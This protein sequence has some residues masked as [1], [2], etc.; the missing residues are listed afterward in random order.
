MTLRQRPK[1]RAEKELWPWWWK[2]CGELTELAASGAVVVVNE[3]ELNETAFS[4]LALKQVDRLIHPLAF[5][6][7][8]QVCEKLSGHGVSFCDEID[9]QLCIGGSFDLSEDPHVF[10][11]VTQLQNKLD[12]EAGKRQFLPFSFSD[13]DAAYPAI[14]EAGSWIQAHLQELKKNTGLWLRGC[15]DQLENAI[16]YISAALK[17]LQ[18][19][20]GAPI[21]ALELDLHVGTKS[22]RDEAK[23]A[24]LDD[25]LDDLRLEAEPSE[26]W[27]I[28]GGALVKS[29]AA[30]VWQA[31]EGH[32]PDDG[33]ALQKRVSKLT[34]RIP[35]LHVAKLPGAQPDTE[36]VRIAFN[37]LQAQT[38]DWL[39]LADIGHCLQAEL[40]D[41]SPQFLKTRSV[42]MLW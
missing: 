25:L 37:E 14:E 23:L 33:G 12:A 28:P 8:V 32:W 29:C 17:K 38:G 16:P 2:R 20:D 9:G 4:F 11:I 39:L 31:K 27:L 19:I 15:V 5:N 7:Q 3:E 36:P 26:L 34:E 42:C 35:A 13:S 1:N 10:G 40:Q 30:L 41:L 22:A 6:H 18:K 21:L 24:E